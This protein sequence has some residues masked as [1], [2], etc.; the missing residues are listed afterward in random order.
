[1]VAMHWGRIVDAF[2][3]EPSRPSPDK[4][5]VYIVPTLFRRRFIVITMCLR[6]VDVRSGP[7]GFRVPCFAGTSGG[8]S[9]RV[10]HGPS[11]DNKT[12]F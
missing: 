9:S 7:D 3:V 5:V 6:P 1:M 12:R 4:S 2:A 10:E 8:E 11:D